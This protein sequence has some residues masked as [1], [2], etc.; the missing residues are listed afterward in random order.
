MSTISPNNNLSPLAFYPSLE[1]REQWWGYGRTPNICVPKRT[2]PTFQIRRPHNTLAYVS[3]E[4][5]AD[6]EHSEGYYLDAEGNLT[7]I[8][9][10][11]T[12][13]TFED[14]PSG[15]SSSF[16]LVI[17]RDALADF[18]E[19][20][21]I[22]DDIA[23]LVIG[24]DEE[25]EAEKGVWLENDSLENITLPEDVTNIRVFAEYNGRPI[26]KWVATQRSIAPII[27]FALKDA[28]DG[29]VAL[30]GV[31]AVLRVVN[32]GSYDYIF[33][34]NNAIASLLLEKTYYLEISDGTNRW[35]SDNFTMRDDNYLK[36]EWWNENNLEMSDGT[37]MVAKYTTP[38]P[39]VSNYPYIPTLYIHS[40]I[41]MPDYEFEE[42]VE[43]RG[44]Y[45]FPLQQI[46][47]KRYKF[48]FLAPEVVCDAMRL[49]R[50]SDHIRITKGDKVYTANTFLMT[51]TWQDQGYLASVDCE[52]TTDTIV[53]KNGLAL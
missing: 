20:N 29:S 49:I 34:T 32:V 48:N 38:A 2:Y 26:V 36:L 11:C 1:A 27:D 51:P 10:E 42:E 45:Q 37:V 19:D 18:K 12:T 21:E 24:W 31:P 52:F 50:L 6:W 23:I 4:S 25:G 22:E 33:L 35:Y 5:V 9:A 17:D 13:L 40:D 44:G 3:L 47:Y 30:S 41:G 43:E 16:S 46:S 28:K 7:H 39:L 8:D 53:K 14:A 15:L